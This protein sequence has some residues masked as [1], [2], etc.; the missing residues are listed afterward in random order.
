M[1]SFLNDPR[2]RDIFLLMLGF[3]GALW[4]FFDYGNNHP[5]STL[6]IN[7]S[8]EEVLAKAD[9]IFLMLD[10]QPVKFK[11][12]ASITSNNELIDRIQGYYG[13]FKY[14]KNSGQEN[15]SL[16]PIHNWQ[17]EEFSVVDDQVKDAVTMQ[18]SHTGELVS[19]EVSNEILSNQT[20]YSRKNIRS[21]FS[22]IPGYSSQVEDSIIAK[23]VNYQHLRTNELDLNEVPTRSLNISDDIHLWKGLEKLL[24]YSYW[25]RFTFTHDSLH[26]EDD[27]E[28]RFARLFL[29]SSDTLMGV[30]PRLEVEILPAGVL[31]KLSYTLD[32]D[33]PK[34]EQTSSAYISLML[35]LV[36]LGL[37]WLLTSFYLRIKARAI[38]TRPALVVAIIM[39][40]VVPLMFV[41]EY[42]KSYA[43]DLDTRQISEVLNQMMGY[44]VLGALSAIAFFVATSVSDSLTRQ[45]WPEQLKTWDLVRQ[46]MFRNKP[47]G[48]AIIRGIYIGA[49][50]AGAFSMLLNFFSEAYISGQ[51]EFLGDRFVVPALANFIITLL[52]GLA[53]IVAVFLVVGNQVYSYTTKKWAIPVI[54]ALFFALFRPGFVDV[55]PGVYSGIIFGSLGFLFGVFYIR[56]DFL[57]VALGFFIFQNFLSSAN[58]WLVTNSPDTSILYTFVLFLLLLGGAA[59]YFILVG[60]EK[61]SLPEYVPDY[62]EEQA[63]EQRVLQ[64]LDIARNIQLAFLPESTP[65][66]PGFDTSAI[67]VPAQETGGDYYDIICLDDK[68]A[69]IAIGDVSGKG[70]Q[71]AFYMTFVKGV[72][73]SLS[74]IFPS[75]KTMLFRA[76]KLFN[77]NA[78]RGTFISMIY[79][80]LDISDNTF[81]FVR[82]GH[83]PILYKKADGTIEWLQPKGVALGMA[84]GELF[85]KVC[86]EYEVVLSKGDVLVLYTDGI[87]EAQNEAEEFYDEKRLKKL[88]K[89]A[90]VDSALE[91]RDLIIEDVRTFI[92]DER[93]FDDMT[94]VVIKA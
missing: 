87:T 19:F 94:L 4:F 38:D 50:A 57:S 54:S 92:G 71:A 17:V 48:W 79:G 86:E 25:N 55:L 62:I 74:S 10:Y 49:I 12:K 7:Y 16:L 66:I 3:M 8:S 11:K 18:L 23:L 59:F 89:R 60:D 64:E 47:V 76:N 46:G 88:I 75:P 73:H 70:I 78:T 5:L 80:V 85:N 30:T 83:N 43:V 1:F 29:S 20:P 51:V 33:L 35:G 24:K 84:K 81:R 72:I 42:I 2:F 9:S 56:F 28:V 93:Q 53:V 61:D 39:G 90:K 45:Y 21:F 69:A 6:E 65:K 52:T 58:G 15:H 22:S 37:V 63:K 82:A 68:K 44:G 14:I 34:I 36:L 26:L 31:K 40:F 41:L 91:L 13:R 77:E 67:C 27:G 32:N